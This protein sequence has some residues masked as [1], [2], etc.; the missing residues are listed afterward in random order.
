M[1]VAKAVNL[2]CKALTLRPVSALFVFCVSLE[3]VD[4][5]SCFIL[6]ALLRKK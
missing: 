5:I 2:H 6:R 4:E 3:T 1:L